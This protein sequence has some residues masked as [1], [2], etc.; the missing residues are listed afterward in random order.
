MGRNPTA[1]VTRTRKDKI[2][3]SGDERGWLDGGEEVARKHK[4]SSG[5]EG[6]EEHDAEE[7]S[8]GECTPCS[9]I[10]LVFAGLNANNLW[11]EKRCQS[12]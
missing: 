3:G 10:G 7:E 8:F 1:S 6:S 11:M 5:D 2:E 9:I 12:R 4:K